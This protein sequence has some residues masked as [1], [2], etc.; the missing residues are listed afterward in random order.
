MYVKSAYLSLC[1]QLPAK[2][3]AVLDLQQ[4]LESDHTALEMGSWLKTSH[5]ANLQ[6]YKNS[7]KA[8]ESVTRLASREFTDKLEREKNDSNVFFFPMMR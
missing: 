8:N 7:V 5:S 6:I 1:L 4:V 3:D 2:T